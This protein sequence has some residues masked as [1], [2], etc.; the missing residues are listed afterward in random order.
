MKSL[1]PLLSLT[2]AASCA[3]AAEAYTEWNDGQGLTYHIFSNGDAAL[4]SVAANTREVT[5]PASIMV[6]G[7]EH[8][9]TEWEG[10]DLSQVEQLVIEMPLTEIPYS[11]FYDHVNLKSVTLPATLTAIGDYAFYHTG[12]L[13]I[14]FPNALSSIGSYAFANSSLAFIDVPAE[15]TAVGSYA[16][17]NTPVKMVS[18][19]AQNGAITPDLFEGCANLRVLRLGE[20]VASIGKAAVTSKYGDGW[21]WS[22]YLECEEAFKDS[23]LTDVYI[24]NTTPPTWYMDWYTD[25]FDYRNIFF[26]AKLTTTNKDITLHIPTSATEQYNSYTY[27]LGRVMQTR[28][29]YDINQNLWI[30]PY[31]PSAQ[32]ARFKHIDT[33][34]GGIIVPETIT[35]SGQNVITTTTPGQLTAEFLPANTNLCQLIWSSDNTSVAT[36]DGNGRVTGVEV[37]TANIYAESPFSGAKS[38]PFRMTVANISPTDF[39]L[40]RYADPLVIG[41]GGEYTLTPAYKPEVC[42]EGLLFTS[43]DTDIATVDPNGTVKAIRRGS[44]VITGT[45][46]FGG[47]TRTLDVTV[48]PTAT[49][50]VINPIAENPVAGGQ[51]VQLSAEVRPEA[52]SREVVMWSVDSDTDCFTISRDGLLTP[53][54]PGFGYVMARTPDGLK[55]R[56]YYNIDYAPAERIIMPESITLDHLEIMKIETTVEPALASQSVQLTSDNPRI[57]D[58]NYKGNIIGLAAGEA[59]ITATNAAGNITA[60]TK[61]TVNPCGEYAVNLSAT[62]MRFDSDLK[63][64]TGEPLP[65][66]SVCTKPGLPLQNAS[67]SYEISDNIK[68]GYRL[69]VQS[70]EP[71][72]YGEKLA[73][74]AS[75]GFFPGYNQVGFS[76]TIVDVPRYWSISDESVAR[77]YPIIQNYLD[78]YHYTIYYAPYAKEI[79]VIPLGPGSAIITYD[80]EDGSGLTAT[81]EITVSPTVGIGNIDTEA[82]ITITTSGSRILATNP[83]RKEIAVYTADGTLVARGDSET[84]ATPTLTP[85]IYIVATAEGTTKIAL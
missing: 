45:A 74:A 66:A 15:V 55:A 14:E 25:Y 53:L 37:G 3:L 33:F 69:S 32:N 85:G 43:S 4:Y 44:C 62:E 27:H 68:S 82:G 67:S 34:E 57:V 70:T 81:C 65:Y 42:S 46:I 41:I 7:T 31:R 78:Y 84:F 58:V 50:L 10:C 1:K 19:N 61:V 24:E 73:A 48:V 52:S 75:A 20:N 76:E 40:D 8:P 6:D 11:R 49:E 56:T 18:Y 79:A 47:E 72:E 54:K 26:N 80:P 63:N 9:V 16:F 21:Q 36:V 2:L 83:S 23:P 64:I 77:I 28:A 12:I 71:A 22:G 38:E 5:I 60:T 17:S 30:A 59:T 39:S 13:S 51:S 29:P 35:I